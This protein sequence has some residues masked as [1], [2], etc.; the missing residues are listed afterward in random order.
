MDAE[1]LLNATAYSLAND[2]KEKGQYREAAEQYALIKGYLDAAA[3]AE[4][5]YDLYYSDAYETAR[6][7]IKAKDYKTAVEALDPLDRQNPGE[8]YKNVQT[9]YEDAV[10]RYA[11]DL[12]NAKKPFEALPLYRKIPGY[13]DVDNHKL[14]RVPYRIL[15]TWQTESGL[16]MEFREDGTCTI[17]GRKYFFFAQNYLLAVGDRQD[18]LNIKYNIL[19]LSDKNFNL[20]KESPRTNYRMTR[21]API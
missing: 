17:D 14:T 13:K 20:R 7:A 9:M 5:S 12:Y 18:E 4:E 19:A 6:A 21:T 2:L 11:N 10:Y 8:K 3:L 15:G 16:T 1:E